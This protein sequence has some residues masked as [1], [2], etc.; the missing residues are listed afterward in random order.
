MKA[1]CY[2]C[3]FRGSAP[4]SAHSECNH[5]SVKEIMGDPLLGI[6]SMMGGARK[7]SAPRIEGGSAPKFNQHGIDNGWA[8][9]P[10]NF[11]PIWLEE[12]NLFKE[13]ADEKRQLNHQ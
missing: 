1:N 6:M 4:G 3:E 11:D 2:D 8:N 7:L 12:C 5:P 13:N 9:W 10:F